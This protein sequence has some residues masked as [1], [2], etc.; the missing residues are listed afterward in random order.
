MGQNSFMGR[1]RVLKTI[2][3]H[4]FHGH[5]ATSAKS[6]ANT[7]SQQALTFNLERKVFKHSR[8]KTSNSLT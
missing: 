7:Q 8:K 2:S 3:F 4:I 5:D 6:A 1:E